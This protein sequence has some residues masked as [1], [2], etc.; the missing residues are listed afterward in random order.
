VGA[1]DVVLSNTP[2]A[3]AAANE[4]ITGSAQNITLAAGVGT[5]YLHY[6]NTSAMWRVVVHEQGRPIAYTPTVAAQTGSF[7]TVSATGRYTLRKRVCAVQVVIT[8]TAIGTAAGYFS[9]TLPFT[10]AAQTYV[11][12]GIN[13]SNAIALT[14][15]VAASSSTV[16]LYKYDS[17]APTTGNHVLAATI[18]YEI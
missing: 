8:I 10:A 12:V 11:G 2:T 5:A 15:Y 3:S 17:G 18:T 4:I 6:D 14:S 1:G 16:L 13:V 7:T 9:A